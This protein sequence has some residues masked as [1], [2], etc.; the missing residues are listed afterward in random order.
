LIPVLFIKV[1]N[2]D[3][4]LSMQE[5]QNVSNARKLTPQTIFIV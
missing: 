1:N 5:K 3:L 2:R 4:F